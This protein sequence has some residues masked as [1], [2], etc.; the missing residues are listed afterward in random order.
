MG[1][2]IPPR[3]L[4]INRDRWP[5]LP[6]DYEDFNQLLEG[7]ADLHDHEGQPVY[8]LSFKRFLNSPWCKDLEMAPEGEQ[9]D[10]S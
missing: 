2:R 3:D 10:Q 6:A 9:T 7:P 1:E 5:V 4:N 8:T